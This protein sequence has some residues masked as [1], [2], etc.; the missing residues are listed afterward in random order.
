MLR[1]IR[2]ATQLNFEIET[3]SLNAIKEQSHRIE[4]ITKERINAELQK[5]LESKK[6]S[7]GFLLLEKT[8]LLQRIIPELTDL[9]GVSTYS[10]GA[11]AQR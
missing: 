9:K 8:G 3:A 11:K 6:P 5:I 7:V 2:F 4:I 1:A 10:R